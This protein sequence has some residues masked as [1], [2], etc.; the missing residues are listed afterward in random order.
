MVIGPRPC[1]SVQTRHGF[2]VVI[3]HIRCH[4]GKLL[5]RYFHA[6][7]KVRHQHLDGG[8]GILLTDMLD[9]L[10][11]MGCAAILE[12]IPVNGSHHYVLQIHFIDDRQFQYHDHP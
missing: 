1:L 7:A 12:I 2:K 10:T 8:I 3:E 9:A 4:L 5:Q 6:S 11:I